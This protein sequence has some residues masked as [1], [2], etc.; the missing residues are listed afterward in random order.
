MHI[1]QSSDQGGGGPA[2]TEQAPASPR[3]VVAWGIILLSIALSSAIGGGAVASAPPKVTVTSPVQGATGVVP[4]SKVTVTF[5]EPM[6][7][8]SLTTSTLTLRK[9]GTTAPVRA[10]VSYQGTIRAAT[11]TPDLPLAPGATYTAT[12]KGGQT[13]ARSA[14][15][16]PLPADTV[17]SFNVAPAAPA[18]RAQ[19]TPSAN[20]GVAGAG[21]ATSLPRT[22]AGQPREARGSDFDFDPALR[23]ASAR[24]L[25][26]S[27]P[28]ASSATTQPTTARPTPPAA[29]DQFRE[30]P[31]TDFDF[32]PAVRVASAR[33]LTASPQPAPKEAG[34]TTP[35]ITPRPAQ[36]VG[37]AATINQPGRGK[38][39]ISAAPTRG[40]T[41]AARA[42]DD[43]LAEG[44]AEPSACSFRLG[45]ALLHELLP[46]ITGLCLE[47]EWHDA[48]NGD[49]LQRTTGG[50]LVWRKADNWT[51]FTDGATTWLNGPQGVQSRPNTAPG[52]DWEAA[53]APSSLMASAA[54]SAAPATAAEALFGPAASHLR[55]AEAG[56][57]IALGAPL[58][59]P[60]ADVVV[61][62]TFRKLGGPSGGGYGIIVR[63]QA[64]E[65]RDG[66]NQ[67]GRFYVLEVGDRGEVGIWRREGDIWI[68]LLPW[69]RSDAVHPG[70][71]TNELTA[72]AVRSQ[73]TFLVNGWGVATVTDASLAGGGVG[74]FVG[75][76]LNEVAIEDFSVQAPNS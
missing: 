42:G 3:R 48:L 19:A 74:V 66:T 63:D 43:D 35:A 25:A 29:A 18:P 2:R 39:S 61:S 45:F 57:F 40:A 67:S 13:G 73:L 64:S 50:L 10:S 70:E 33:Q 1:F 36:L 71:A 5:G 68:D 8:A 69:T 49:A 14:A 16:I 37:G 9:Q 52:F 38:P 12:I 76:D 6:N 31:G 28:P 65:E 27:R 7:P 54:P 59:S 23:I 15:G 34:P 26:A 62:G 22:S 51:A 60:F 56:R 46:N 17:W 55:V 44:Q 21:G 72:L 32:D 75:G 20:A 24:Q 11:L 58:A 53:P 47:N 4:S 30:A 41:D